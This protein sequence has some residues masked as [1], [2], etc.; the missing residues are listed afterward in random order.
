MGSHA[1]DSETAYSLSKPRNSGQG[2]TENA[3]YSIALPKLHQHQPQAYGAAGSAI[4]GVFTGD[5]RPI[6]WVSELLP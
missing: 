3:I 1:A 5:A 4:R 6:N 2:Y